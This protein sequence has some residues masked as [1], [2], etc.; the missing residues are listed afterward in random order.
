MA[1]QSREVLKCPSKDCVFYKFRL[2]TGRP[3]L[4]Q[5]RKF[6]FDCGEGTYNAVK[7]CKFPDCPLYPYRLG[8]NP[9]LEGRCNIPLEK[10]K[11]FKKKL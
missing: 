10:R 5:I 8:H 3:K 9:K 7:N 11:S 6:C 2:G 4:K 1:G